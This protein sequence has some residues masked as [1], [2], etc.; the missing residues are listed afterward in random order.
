MAKVAAFSK[1]EWKNPFIDLNKCFCYREI[2]YQREAF[3]FSSYFF[4]AW[5]FI[6]HPFTITLS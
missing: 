6:L 2:V 5:I 3:P 1:R 4:K